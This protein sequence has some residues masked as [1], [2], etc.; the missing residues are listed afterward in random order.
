MASKRLLQLAK[1][2]PQGAVVADIGTDHAYLPGYLVQQGISPKVIAVEVNPGPLL[3]ARDNIAKHQLGGR[4]E[5][6]QGNGLE[7]LH[8]GEVQVVVIAGMGG[9]TIVEVLE[10][11]PRQVKSLEELILQPNVDAHLVRCWL[12]E[13]GWALADEELVREND[14]IYEIITAKQRKNGR[15]GQGMDWGLLEAG[16]VLVAKNHPLLPC[17]LQEKVKHYRHVLDQL[18]KSN[19]PQALEKK[20]NIIKKVKS[21]EGVIEWVSNASPSCN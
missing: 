7:P 6:R 15:L 14:R 12:L 11:S 9:K 3:V 8:P 18:E 2:V 21:L 13:N 5:L 20:E 4:I 17:F 10:Q 19:S 16:P 1:M